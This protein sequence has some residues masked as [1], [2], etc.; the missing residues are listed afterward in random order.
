MTN[1]LL[2]KFG[3]GA[4]LALLVPASAG[5]VVQSGAEPST[6]KSFSYEI[7]DGKRVPKANR[8]TNSDGSWREE[9]RQGTCVTIKQK[10]A[11]GDYSETRKCD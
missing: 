7:R 6:P 11:A 9:V 8:V 4:A 10:T 3:M 5:A 1:S 2:V